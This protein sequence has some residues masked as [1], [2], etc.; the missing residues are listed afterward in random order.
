MSSLSAGLTNLLPATTTRRNRQWFGRSNR[1]ASCR[2]HALRPGA[3]TVVAQTSLPSLRAASH[4]EAT[5]SPDWL[6]RDISCVIVTMSSMERR[7][8]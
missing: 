7:E 8:Q 3:V 1:K 4:S 5:E 2:A 6:Y